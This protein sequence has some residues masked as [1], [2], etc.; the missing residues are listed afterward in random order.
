M[1][2]KVN[3]VT[4][5]GLVENMPDGNA[6]R[7]SDV[8]K[9]AEGFTVEVL[10]TDAEGRLVLIDLFYYVR[11]YFKPKTIIDV[12]TLTGAIGISLG[13]AFAGLFCNDKSLTKSLEKAGSKTGE[14]V[15]SMPLDKVYHDQLKSSY[16]D[17]ANIPTVSLGLAGSCT[18]AAFLEFFIKGEKWAHIDI[19]YSAYGRSGHLNVQGATGW[20]RILN[21]VIR[22]KEV[23]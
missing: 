1:K 21:E 8:V 6:Q 11:K 14:R 19:A 2:E 17:I 4:I 9:S 15:W 16:A 22:S 7:P 10:N 5:V 18:A 20:H 23:L 3:L 13:T 12:A